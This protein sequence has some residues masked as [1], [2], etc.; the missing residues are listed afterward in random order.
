[1]SFWVAGTALVGTVG[2]A[3]INKSSSDKA[4]QA[5][6]DAAASVQPVDIGSLNDQVV[7]QQTAN[8]KAAKALQDQL[9]PGV[10]TLQNTSISDLLAKLQPDQYTE[11]IKALLSKSLTGDSSINPSLLN[12]AVS[13]AQQQLD[14]GGK[15]DAETQNQIMRAAL[16]KAG[17]VAPGGLGLGRD[18]TAR[19]LGLTS[20]QLQQ[21]RLQNAST[22]GGQQLN[23]QQ[24]QS[25]QTLNQQQMLAALA[26]GDWT[27][28]LQA[29]QFAQSIQ[30][31]S[32]GLS[33]TDVA[34][35][36]TGNQNQ[37][38]AK[39]L[40]AGNL[41]AAGDVA[42][43]NADSSILGGLTSSKTVNALSSLFN[44]TSPGG[45]DSVDE[46]LPVGGSTK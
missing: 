20:L 14:L 43:G 39:I 28:Y 46:S 8:A 21:Q 15:L 23:E 10:S 1:M 35:I 9:N 42:G 31:P 32:L 2:S 41:T 3:L 4:L 29:A 30:T 16:A 25:Q 40:Q 24:A 44:Q 17:N 27:K 13:S 45:S 26:S 34:N 33:S 18:I 37:S 19:D 38:N 12:S 5:Q 7:S 36:A 11:Q 6:K 22:I